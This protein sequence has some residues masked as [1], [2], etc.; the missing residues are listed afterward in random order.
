MT[1]YGKSMPKHSYEKP[2]RIVKIIMNRYK[3]GYMRSIYGDILI[4]NI[5]SYLFVMRLSCMFNVG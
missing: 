3:Y 5:E 4:T 2:R 1:I